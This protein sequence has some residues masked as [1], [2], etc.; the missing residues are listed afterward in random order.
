M[1][2]VVFNRIWA[3]PSG[4]TFS[5]P[6]IAEF[7]RRWIAGRSVVVDPFA[8]NSRLAT[9][10]NDLNP[11]TAAEYHQQADE[12]LLSLNRSGLSADAIILDPPYSPRQI[13]ELY[14]EIGMPCTMK[15]TQD[16]AFM[17]RVCDAAHKITRPGSVILSFGWNSGG[18]GMRKHYAIQ[19]ILLV[20][21]GARK[22]DTIC[23]AE[24][25]LDNLQPDLLTT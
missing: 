7:V 24:E 2:G 21:H 4:D 18:M 17:R 15:D 6:P 8:R 22:N 11:A 10:R 16:S 23:M 9:Y 5:I 19:E 3:M 1:T 20:N 12:F 14:K 25:R 13:S